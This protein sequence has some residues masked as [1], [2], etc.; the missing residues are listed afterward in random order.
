MIRRAIE[1][2]RA[3]GLNEVVFIGAD[4][5]DGVLAHISPADAEAVVC[6]F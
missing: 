5:V 3:G 2:A 4:A 6:A 1:R